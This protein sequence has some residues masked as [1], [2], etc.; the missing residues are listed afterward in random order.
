MCRSHARNAFNGTEKVIDDVSPVTE[1]IEDNTATVFNAVVPRRT[2]RRNRIALE[3]PI[4]EFAADSNNPSEKIGV[5]QAFQ[6]L[7]T[8]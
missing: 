1:H 2:L 5:Y 7:D 6:F 8:R 4:A 3:D